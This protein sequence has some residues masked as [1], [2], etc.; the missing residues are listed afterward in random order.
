MPIIEDNFDPSILELITSGFD[1]V[2]TFDPV[3]GDYVRMSV[4]DRQGTLVSIYRSD[5]TWDIN[6]AT[7]SPNKIFYDNDWTP[8]FNL[9]G[10]VYSE[11]ISFPYINQVQLPIYKD[12]DGK[13][14]VKPNDTL[15]ADPNIDYNKGFYTLKFDFIWDSFNGAI[16]GLGYVNPKFYLRE[17]SPSRTEVRLLVRQNI[18][19]NNSEQVP[20]NQQFMDAFSDLN[21]GLSDLTWVL[22]LPEAKNINIL[23]YAFDNI[24]IP[25][26]NSL[27]LKLS[28]EVP[29]DVKSPQS[30]NIMIGKEIYPTQTEEIFYITEDA[31]DDEIYSLTPDNTIETDNSTLSYDIPQSYNDLIGTSSTFSDGDASN[32]ELS[33]YS[34][35]HDNLNIDYSE[36][37][38]YAFFGSAEQKLKNFYNKIKKIEDYSLEIS[39]SMTSIPSDHIDATFVTESSVVE[40]RRNLF[41][42]INEIVTNFT[43]YELWMYR[44]NIHSG[45]YPKSGKDHSNYP[46]I[47]G[48]FNEYFGNDISGDASVIKDYYGFKTVYKISTGDDNIISQSNFTGDDSIGSSLYDTWYTGSTSNWRFENNEIGYVP[49]GGDTK[50][51]HISGGLDDTLFNKLDDPHTVQ[52]FSLFRNNTKYKIRFKLSTCYVGDNL[53]FRLGGEEGA[54][55]KI[56][57]V[58]VTDSGSYFEHVL[59]VE[60]ASFPGENY[61]YLVIDA[62]SLFSGS[63]DDI[64]ILAATDVDGRADI[65]TDQYRVEDYPFHHYNGKYYLSFLASWDSLPHW[66]NYNASQSVNSL[67][68]TIEPIPMDA[69]NSE[70]IQTQTEESN[71]SGSFHRYILAASQSYWRYPD[72]ESI[73]LTALDEADATNSTFGWE[74]LDGE[75]ITGSYG[76]N[77]LN[78]NNLYNE[79]Y[80]Y[81]SS[82]ILPSGE[83]FR[84]YHITSSDALAPVSHSYVMDVKLFREDNIWSGQPSD[85]IDFSHLYST[86]SNAV[87][88]WYENRIDSASQYDRQNVHYLYNQLPQFIR[89]EDET[90]TLE[91]FINVIAEQFDALKNYIDN[92]IH[93]NYRSYQEIDSIPYNIIE[94]IGS[95]FGWKFINT[96]ALKNLLDYHIGNKKKSAY[97]DVSAQIWKNV[98]NNLI[99]IYKSKGTE[100]SVRAL[101]NSFG[102]PPNILTVRELGGSLES[103]TNPTVDFL[104]P[105]GVEFSVGNVSYNKEQRYIQSMNINER[106][107][108]SFKTDWNTS[109][110]G[111][112][113]GVEFIG[114]FQHNNATQSI[115]LSS[116]SYRQNWDLVYHPDQNSDKN[117]HLELRTNLIETGSVLIE[118]WPVSQT[119]LVS[120]SLPLTEDGGKYPWHILVQ[121]IEASDYGAYN[122]NFP[123]TSSLEMHVARRIG[124][125]ITHYWSGSVD[126]SGSSSTNFISTGSGAVLKSDNLVF[127][128]PGASDITFA[129]PFT[130]SISEVRVLA[131]PITASKFY[132]HVFNP[133][134]VV[135]NTQDG[136]MDIIHRYSFKGNYF[137]DDDYIVI[138]DNGS[139]VSGSKPVTISKSNVT[140]LPSF[141]KNY[142]DFYEFNPRSIDLKQFNSK[143]VIVSD[144]REFIG[145]E[146]SPVENRSVGDLYVDKELKRIR[147]FDPIV[148]ISISPARVIDRLITS[149]VS[150]WYLGDLLGDPLDNSKS[151]YTDLTVFAKRLFGQFDGLIDVNQWIRSQAG[152]IP[153]GFWT[154]L[155]EILPASVQSI[156]GLTIENH[157]LFRNKNPKDLLDSS[158]KYN[159]Y[160]TA[161][162]Y[163]A[164]TD[165]S[166]ANSFVPE[167]I[168][169][170]PS[171]VVTDDITVEATNPIP[172]MATDF[173]NFETDYNVTSEVKKDLS[174]KILINTDT[175]IMMTSFINGLLIDTISL[176]ESEDNPDGVDINSWF[177]YPTEAVIELEE[178]IIIS[179]IHN[180]VK[181]ADIDVP[182]HIS[183]S[184][185]VPYKSEDIDLSYISNLDSEFKD[186]LDS[187]ID[188]SNLSVLSSSIKEHVVSEDIDLS[189]ITNLETSVPE[190]HTSNIPITDLK[191][192]SSSIQDHPLSEDIDL[193]DITDIKTSF[194][195]SLDSN[196][197]ISSLSVLSSSLQDKLISRDIDLSDLSDIN[198]SFEDKI[199]FDINISSLSTISSSFEHKITSNKIDLSDL[200]D[201]NSSFEDKIKFNLDVSNLNVISSSFKDNIS[202][203]KIDLSDLSDIDSQF[204]DI[205]MVDDI[206]MGLVS[207]NMV[208]ASLYDYIDQTNRLQKNEVATITSFKQI[209]PT[210]EESKSFIRGSS[211]HRKGKWDSEK[212]L[213]P[214]NENY[215]IDVG[216]SPHAT[217]RPHWTMQPVSGAFYETEMVFRSIGDTE[218]LNFWGDRYSVTQPHSDYPNVVVYGR[219]WHNYDNDHPQM[220]GGRNIMKNRPGKGGAPGG[221]RG[222]HDGR[223]IGRTQRIYTW[224][225][226]SDTFVEFSNEGFT[227]G[228][229]FEKIYYPPDSYFKIGW[230]LKNQRIKRVTTNHGPTA[231]GVPATDAGGNSVFGNKGGDLLKRG[232]Y[233]PENLITG[234][235]EVVISRQVQGGSKK[236]KVSNPD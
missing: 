79:L 190:H 174:G 213:D 187:K 45:S 104:N 201:I 199:R 229:D 231:G 218:T 37:E 179:T 207:H 93:L 77:I 235:T 180:D 128:D 117:A 120:D 48:S 171:I 114:T 40:R 19:Q 210:G 3:A 57:T 81:G 136:F 18:T 223:K 31:V 161:Q 53:T 197:N 9:T 134:S 56:F 236:L 75:N 26:T 126:V 24:S 46:P 98:L 181:I 186:S 41:K 95:N 132:T 21:V 22:G 38:N 36:F 177:D 88:T 157:L 228:D 193:S 29:I 118:A 206:D 52:N 94:I 8:F 47:S 212:Y 122:N 222:R 6:S 78:Q 96:G 141:R 109:E 82:S 35:S 138:K 216:V 76:Q 224:K 184:I 34:Q 64:E 69:F 25:N 139:G 156:T 123:L 220:F 68:E 146:L 61:N 145:T 163:T 87:N 167:I 170:T 119:T 196:I 33:V 183:S 50:L 221:N 80:S 155:E 172:P 153:D 130:G 4:Y 30:K 28:G 2:D 148:D 17:I 205:L 198:T 89:D 202:V 208:S 58:D 125:T 39:S 129:A 32:V 225:H 233:D 217:F 73:Q 91:K 11:E 103:Q 67:G 106:S 99:Y 14:Y 116:G 112:N 178:D 100:N 101:L 124:D 204:Q 60:A 51:Y 143:K 102:L 189:D 15:D 92:Y 105:E 127:G 84:L 121:R 13:V 219:D 147:N 175:S 227:W 115:L 169:N 188:I 83:L 111:L 107:T 55:S 113:V 192:L 185:H 154:T 62:G 140:R 162:V 74:I 12:S 135:G 200:S 215:V 168:S 49:G 59:D 226:F 20:L 144:K 164:R 7:G 70:S 209:V 137:K 85:I 42:N 86:S 232:W 54:E 44:N 142:Y 234:R 194:K 133:D 150:D 16:G 203:D 65:F 151:N 23:N 173:Y 176:I 72:D 165:H 97:K 71:T 131:Q 191:V 108:N 27:V 149:Y 182:D 66:E 195:D 5:S 10:D 43:P 63:L 158:K 110:S 159:G 160:P 1:S 230:T 211:F 90:K 214:T 152:M 166:M